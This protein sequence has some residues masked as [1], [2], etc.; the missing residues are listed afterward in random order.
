MAKKRSKIK[1]DI[2]LR[3]RILYMFFM[4]VCAVVVL[5]LVWVQFF[6]GE[7][8][9]NAS[10]L[11]SRIITESRLPA[12]R[13]AILSRNGEPLLISVYRHQVYFDFGAEGLD[14]IAIFN[15]QSDSLSKLLSGFFRDRSVAEYRR[16]FRREHAKRYRLVRG[17]D[18]TMLRSEGWF[19]QFIDR[20]RGEEFVKKRIYDTLR[21]HTPVP[22]FPREV[23]LSEWEV[24]RRYPI[25]NWNM[26]FVYRLEK[27]EKRL[28]PQGDLAHRTIGHGEPHNYG[29][30]YCYNDEL[31]G[32]D[33]LITRQR[34]AHGSTVRVAGGKNVE[35][36]N[37]YDIL[38]TIDEELQDVADK[39]LRAQMERQRA[40]W[41]TT[42]VMETRTGEIL[43]MANLGRDERSNSYVYTERQ[44][45]A[46]SKSMEP[47]STFKL[48]TMLALLDDADMPTT[49]TYDSNHGKKV[50]VGGA[51]IVDTH[52]EDGVIDFRKAV[53]S[54]S[55]IYFASAVWDRY[56][57]DKNR[58][59]NYLKEDLRLGETVGL[60]KL[61][62]VPPS[63]GSFENVP[64]PGI[65][66]VKMAYG[67]RLTITPI[68]ML[69]FFNAIANDGCMI[70]PIIVKELRRDGRTEERYESKVLRSSICSHRTLETVRDA[71]V[72]VT[73]KHG[74]A[75]WLF[76]DSIP[77]KVMAKTGTAQVTDSRRARGERHYLGSM[78]AM[79][80][81][82]NPQYTILT[83]IENEFSPHTRYS[84]AALAGPVVKRMVDYIY[85]RG[86][87]RTD[88]AGSRGRNQAPQSIKGG[89]I[90]RMRRVAG[91]FSPDVDYDRRK[92]WGRARVDTL[93]RVDIAAM[94]IT[95]GVV[96]DVRGMGLRDALF[97]LE[98]RGMK[99]RFR[100]KGRVVRQSIAGGSRIKG[101]PTIEIILG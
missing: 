83:A 61:G 51:D 88:V 84:G 63:L 25:L 67:Y 2:L 73:H 52:K 4:L 65:K 39:A 27:T 99:V 74:T 22:L 21:D 24:L 17:R 77:L 16:F 41:G 92:G 87:N 34:I 79:F 76:R 46:L 85:N 58:Y 48:A 19:Q 11:K 90:S 81:A 57:N 35:P 40:T 7:V 100:G 20:M 44:N 66:L 45:Y 42:L 69:T 89:S 13:G 95:Q 32:R 8:A 28:Y 68:Q 23:N 49:V 78:V 12:Q 31:K 26:G 30:E 10:R 94:E 9:Y 47:G 82:E 14:S 3:V 97:L 59:L 15:E 38:T 5:R 62:E 72:A 98:S 75:D 18:T 56:K 50:R 93:S 80:P 86:H 60:E 53:A 96:P 29:I 1:S 70:S 36:E 64:D 54:S 33:G 6:S 55:N 43:A 91:E 71:L 101:T 37:G